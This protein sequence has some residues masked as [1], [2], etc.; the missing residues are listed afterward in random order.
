VAIPCPACAHDL[1]AL[2]LTWL[3]TCPLESIC[4]ECGRRFEWRNLLNPTRAGHPQNFEHS[5]H[6]LA[7]RWLITSLA[8]LWPPALWRIVQPEHPRRLGR[9]AFL[10]AAWIAL[11]QLW[12]MAMYTFLRRPDSAVRV[13]DLAGKPNALWPWD[14][15]VNFPAR[16]PWG[17]EAARQGLLMDTEVS[18]ITILIPIAGA[19]VVLLPAAIATRR[20]TLDVL[21]AWLLSIPPALVL[22]IL[23]LLFMG[24]VYAIEA[25]LAAPDYRSRP[26]LVWVLYLFAISWHTVAMGAWWRAAFARYFRLPRPGAAAILLVLAI[27]FLAFTGLQIR[28]QFTKPAMRHAPQ[29]A[30]P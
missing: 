6:H 24:L 29:S 21:R 22:G 5:R 23:H 1:S 10:A 12:G 20:R 4:P 8:T 26:A 13:Y 11:F 3:N 7:R 16:A 25:R 9:L 19:L 17:T 30:R 2:P 18:F 15:Q 27:T 28:A 14:G